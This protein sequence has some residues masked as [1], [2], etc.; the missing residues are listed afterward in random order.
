VAGPMHSTVARAQPHSRGQGSYYGCGSCSRS[1]P[2]HKH[3]DGGQSMSRQRALLGALGSDADLMRGGF[4]VV[5]S[6]SLSAILSRPALGS[7]APAI[8]KPRRDLHVFVLATARSLRV[9]SWLHFRPGKLARVRGDARSI[10][11]PFP[12]RWNRLRPFHAL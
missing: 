7:Q 12:A 10:R 3:A 9:S 1:A 4:T 5:T 11:G 8:V 6:R 2:V